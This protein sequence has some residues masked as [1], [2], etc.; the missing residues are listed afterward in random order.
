LCVFVSLVAISIYAANAK[1]DAPSVPQGSLAAACQQAKADFHPITQSDVAQAKTVLLEAVGRL[2]EKLT[3]AG[4]IGEGW[5]KYLHWDL[6]QESLRGDTRRDLDRLTQIYAFFTRGYDGL[7]L[8]WFLDVQHA[9]ENYIVMAGVVGSPHVRTLYESQLDKL[10][11]ALEAYAAKPTTENALVISQVVRWLQ[12][13]HQAPALVEAIQQRYVHPNVMGQVSAELVAVGIVD[14]VDDVTQINDC[15]LGTTVTGTAHTIGRISSVLAPN[16]EMGVI[17]TLFCGRTHSENVG[18]HHP[19]TIFSTAETGLCACKRVWIDQNG[20]SSLPSG[21]NAVTHVCIQDIQSRKDRGIVQRMAWK[22]AGQQQG[23]AE[24]IASRHAEQRLNERIDQQ[25]AEPLDKANQQYVEK[26]KKPFSDRGLFPQLLRFS[27][28][29]RALGLLGLQAGGGKVAAPDSPPPVMEGADMTLQLHESAINN[30]AFDAL[31]GRT[32]YEEKVQAAAKNALGRLPEK[33]K[34]DE[35][36]KPW[37]IT[38]DPKQPVSVTFADNGFKVTIR[39]VKYYKGKEGYPAMNV[40]AVYKI[41]H[42]PA[43]FKAVRQGD[44]EVVPPDLKPGEQIDAQR[45]I[46]RTMLIKRFAKVF[47]P[48]FLGQG[49]ELSG[50]WKAAGKLMPVQVECHDGWLVIAWNRAAV[51]PKTATAKPAV[52]KV[53]VAKVAVAK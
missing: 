34:G 23:E 43:G 36:G 27:T 5:R 12:N 48:E 46:I 18:Y 9:L 38:F 30:L 53:A 33:L 14:S 1:Q 39:G 3:E 4:E 25:A 11:P 16:A 7:E 45:Q 13:A 21:A 26:Y 50:R 28:T 49:I 22:R 41:E 32:I 31:A 15:I 24:C 8:A 44:I 35:D 2:D 47:D 40:S 29:A 6:L 10:A 20:L 42:S 37:A 19:V 17:D 51:G 52:K